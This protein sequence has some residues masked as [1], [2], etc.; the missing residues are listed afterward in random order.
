MLQVMAM[1]VVMTQAVAIVGDLMGVVVVIVAV[2][3]SSN[4]TIKLAIALVSFWKCWVY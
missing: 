2:I 1:E 3:K 4:Y